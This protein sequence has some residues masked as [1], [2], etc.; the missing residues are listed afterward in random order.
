M[1][2][3]SKTEKTFLLPRDDWVFGKLPDDDSHSKVD[4]WTRL[5]AVKLA[6]LISDTRAFE[7]LILGVLNSTHP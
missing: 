4:K 3:F 5:H 2:Q 6:K 7:I 1:T